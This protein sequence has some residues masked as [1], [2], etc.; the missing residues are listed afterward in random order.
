VVPAWRKASPEQ[1]KRLQDE[2]KIL[3]VRTYA[4]ALAQVS[5]QDHHLKPMRAAPDDKD[6]VVRTEI[7]GAGRPDAAGLPRSENPG[8][9]ALAGRSTTSTCWACGWSKPTAAS[10]PQ[11]INAKGMDGLI[12]TLAERNKAN[13]RK[14]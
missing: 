2:F 3:L 8:C 11:E 6:V 4:G 13:A 5:D 14:G 10:L 1:Q 12:A 7:T 9:R